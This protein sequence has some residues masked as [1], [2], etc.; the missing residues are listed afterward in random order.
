M[1]WTKRTL[2]LLAG[3]LLIGAAVAEET[4][5]KPAAD[6]TSEAREIIRKVDTAIKAVNGVRYRA[7][8]LPTGVATNF[9][10]G[11]EGTVVL[12]GW[13]GASPQMFYGDVTS[14]KDGEK[15]RLTGGGNG[16]SYFIIDHSNK[17]AYEDMDPL[18]MGS[19]GGPV[20]SLRMVEFVHNAPF[21]D[22]LKAEDVELLGV[23]KVADVECFKIHVDY[24]SGQQSTWFFSTEDYLPRKRIRHFQSPQ[25]DGTLEQIVMDLEID[26]DVD[27][28]LFKLKL[29]EGY[30]QID[31]F[32]P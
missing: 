11:G 22:E 6:T 31:D 28:S 7:V 2:C 27:A 24:G 5:E 32:A 1:E 20:Q 29:P 8:S 17:K 19:T 3:L 13:T 25:G 18:V 9:T 14:E 12:I 30:E 4:A 26:P 15:R 10:S 16:D 21:D 23:E